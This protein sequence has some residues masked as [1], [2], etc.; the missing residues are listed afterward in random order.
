MDDF[1]EKRGSLVK[2]LWM[3]CAIHRILIQY[4]PAPYTD[5]EYVWKK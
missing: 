5:G 4:P 3:N 1:A 2:K